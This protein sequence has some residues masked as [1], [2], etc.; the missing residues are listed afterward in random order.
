MAD[1]CTIYDLR[2]CSG[3]DTGESWHIIFFQGT[4]NPLRHEERF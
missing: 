1:P 4:T 2:K 3:L